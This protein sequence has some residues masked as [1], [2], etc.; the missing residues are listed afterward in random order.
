MKEQ[1]TFV[2]AIKIER[3]NLPLC[4]RETTLYHMLVGAFL[5][6][7]ECLSPKFIDIFGFRTPLKRKISF[8]AALTSMG[9]GKSRIM[10]DW[11]KEVLKNHDIL[12]GFIS[13]QWLHQLEFSSEDNQP[14]NYAKIE[15]T[16]EAYE[17][18]YIDLNE[19]KEFNKQD[20]AHIF[21]AELYDA[22]ISG[23]YIGVAIPESGLM[24]TASQKDVKNI[25]TKSALYSLIRAAQGM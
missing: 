4:N 20:L 24:D 21:I 1:L 3:H 6:W 9:M 25:L 23:R 22:A 10:T 18:K 12:Q 5:N 8:Q 11:A 13:F 16:S 14:I 15:N 2:G 19:K 7:I 17:F